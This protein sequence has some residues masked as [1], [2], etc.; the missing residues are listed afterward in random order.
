MSQQRPEDA[1]L[2][3]ILLDCPD[4]G[5]SATDVWLKILTYECHG[6][7]YAVVEVVA[8]AKNLIQAEH[9]AV[10]LTSGLMWQES[11]HEHT[12]TKAFL[13]VTRQ[14]SRSNNLS[15]STITSRTLDLLLATYA[16][17]A[18]REQTLSATEL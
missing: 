15:T 3:K 14:K 2:W 5:A 7:M 11:Q 17:S 13:R 16:T 10:L 4:E 8:C 9:G 18:S 12:D 1:Q 6:F